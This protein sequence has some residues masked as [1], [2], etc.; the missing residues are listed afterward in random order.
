MKP[1]IT[2][3][4]STA[5]WTFPKARNNFFAADGGWIVKSQTPHFSRARDCSTQDELPIWRVLKGLGSFHFRYLCRIRMNPWRRY[6]LSASIDGHPRQPYVTG[7]IWMASNRIGPIN[8]C[9]CAVMG[10]LALDG[11]SDRRLSSYGCVTTVLS[12]GLPYVRP[13]RRS[14]CYRPSR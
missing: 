3:T 9:V 14:S 5:Q 11:L 13:I 4:Y 12:N 7:L 6:P 2:K 8:I 1:L 10:S